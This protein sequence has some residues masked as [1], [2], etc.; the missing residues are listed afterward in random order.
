MLAFTCTSMLFYESAQ[1][2]ADQQIKAEIQKKLGSNAK[3]RSVIPAPV[4]G[5]YEVL[6]G[7]EIFYTDSSGKY[8]IQ[9]EIIELLFENFGVHELGQPT[10]THKKALPWEITSQIL[11]Y[12]FYNYLADHNYDLAGALVSTC[13]CLAVSD[14]FVPR[15]ASAHL[16]FVSSLCF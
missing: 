10:L 8:L 3:V 15:L 7:N 6:V 14:I 4:S 1:A 12:L 5:L 2:Q 9:G 13:R 11:K 16:R